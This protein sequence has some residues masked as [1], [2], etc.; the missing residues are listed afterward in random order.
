MARGEY[1][2]DPTIVE[3]VAWEPYGSGHRLVILPPP[4]HTPD[5]REDTPFP[6]GVDAAA[7]ELSASQSPDDLSDASSVDTPV[8][9][10]IPAVLTIVTSM[11]WANQIHTEIYRH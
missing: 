6:D 4:S 11:D 10:P 2:A 5:T 7:T 9:P 1:L 3:K 8:D